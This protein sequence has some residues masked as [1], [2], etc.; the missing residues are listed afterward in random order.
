MFG[1]FEPEEEEVVYGITKQAESWNPVWLNFEYWIE[2]FMDVFK[3]RQIRNAI[4]MLVKMPGWKP[5]EL[6][7]SPV[8]KPVTPGTFHKFNTEIPAGLNY[9]VLFQFIIILIGSTIFLIVQGQTLL[10]ENIW[11]NVGLATLIIYSLLNLGGIF[12]RKSWVLVLEYLRIAVLGMAMI[13]LFKDTPYFMVIAIATVVVTAISLVWFSLYLKE[14][15]LQTH[16]YVQVDA[17]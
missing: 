4:L 14:F 5:E 16:T 13:L 6:G 11:L 1:T 15:R 7:G 8:L 3:V 9:Y 10:K 12:E 2:L 17:R